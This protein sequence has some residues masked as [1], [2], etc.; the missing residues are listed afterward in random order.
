[1][2]K[3]M[4]ESDRATASTLFVRTRSRTCRC[5]GFLAVI[6][7]LVIAVP[8][9]RAQQPQADELEVKLEAVFIYN[10]LKYTQWPADDPDQPYH[11]V[12]LGETP[13]YEYL[14][15]I[16]SDQKVN[17]REILVIRQSRWSA[18]DTC[19]VLY[20]SPDNRR[21]LPDI[22]A[23]IQDKSVLTISDRA[24]SGGGSTTLSFFLED[25]K[26]RFQVDMDLIRKSG[27]RLSSQLL[28]LAR[29]VSGQV[30]E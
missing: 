19:H 22:M 4:T 11:I 16:A 2:N 18:E 27:I 1:M 20:I 28:K 17:G 30:T 15:A 7:F 29:V 10:F 25:G 23:R 9:A 8:C 12:I 21:K 3:S 6:A 5:R 13:V 26:L 14:T 24:N